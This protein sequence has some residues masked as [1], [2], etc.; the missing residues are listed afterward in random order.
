LTTCCTAQPGVQ[1]IGDSL[2]FDDISF[3]RF[4][5]S[6]TPRWHMGRSLLQG[7]MYVQ[8]SNFPRHRVAGPKNASGQLFVT[9]TVALLQMLTRRDGYGLVVLAI[10]KINVA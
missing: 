2:Y 10:E 5:A 6:C 7:Q 8:A 1:A 3:I 4:T 9:P